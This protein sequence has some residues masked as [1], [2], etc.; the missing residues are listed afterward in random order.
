MSEYNLTIPGRPVPKGRPRV[1]KNTRT[2]E[3]TKKREDL[4]LYKWK[5]AHGGIELEGDLAVYCHFNYHDKQTAD[6]DNLIKLVLDALGGDQSGYRPFN[7]KQVIEIAAY[8][9][10]DKGDFEYTSITVGEIDE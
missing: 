5:E 8:L 3:K 10:H 1:G 9:H 4:I 7:D 6:L 2:P